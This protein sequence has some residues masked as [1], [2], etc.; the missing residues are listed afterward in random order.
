MKNTICTALT[1]LALLVIPA[2]TLSA[3]S[4][5][6]WVKIP[7]AFTITDKE[8]P[9][10]QY[11]VETLYWNAVAFQGAKDDRSLILLG[12]PREM[13]SGSQ[14]KLIF[15]RY[16][17]LYFLAEVRLPNMDFA[18]TFAAGK[19]EVEVAKIQKREPNVEIVRR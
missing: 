7:F 8:M 15:H 17:N 11:Y 1:L 14:P 4:R 18:R 6:M 2:A 13:V 12:Q 10:G 9:A 16:G 5:G 19:K 3:Q